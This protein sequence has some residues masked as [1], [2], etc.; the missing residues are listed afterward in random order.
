M[1]KQEK[2]CQ[3]VFD[4]L[5]AQVPQK[6]IAKIVGVNVSTVRRLQHARNAGKSTERASSSGGHNK[7]RTQ[8]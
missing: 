2:N 8:E 3:H 5:D 7:K 4:L 6:G 1:T